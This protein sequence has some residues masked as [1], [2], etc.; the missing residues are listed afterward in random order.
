MFTWGILSGCMAFVWNEWSFYI[1]RFL[2]GAAEAGFFPGIL[3]F[4]T[5]YCL[6]ENPRLCRGGCR[7]LTFPGICSASF[8]HASL[9][10]HSL[11]PWPVAKRPL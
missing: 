10:R 8:G 4:L 1:V 6:R 3:F 5:L 11:A 7:S 9:Q 2:F